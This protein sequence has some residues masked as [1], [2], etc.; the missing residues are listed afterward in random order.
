MIRSVGMGM[1]RL[2][3]IIVVTVD[4]SPIVIA[5][6]GLHMIQVKLFA[7]LAPVN[8]GT[9]SKNNRDDDDGSDGEDT[10]TRAFVLKKGHRRLTG[11]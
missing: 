11:A 5:C 6:H 1:R 8:H 10:G 7:F 4:R 9:D 2:G 3:G